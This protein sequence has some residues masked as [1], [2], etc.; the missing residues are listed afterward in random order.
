M[1]ISPEEGTLDGDPV[2]SAIQY[3]ADRTIVPVDQ[4]FNP[5]ESLWES[6]FEKQQVID[7]EIVIQ[8]KSSILRALQ[9]KKNEFFQAIDIV[10]EGI[11]IAD[12]NGNSVLVKC[13]LKDKTS[14][15]EQFI[16]RVQQGLDNNEA[17][18]DIVEDALFNPISGIVDLQSDSYKA[19][20]EINPNANKEVKDAVI[21][22]INSLPGTSLYNLARTKESS[23]NPLFEKLR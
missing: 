9:S 6:Y 7:N 1:G 2:L 10:D 21:E 12:A 16:T 11:E 18:E 22:L 19:L 13:K 15:F 17:I 4:N 3:V 5:S 20:I 8:I 23:S 14:A